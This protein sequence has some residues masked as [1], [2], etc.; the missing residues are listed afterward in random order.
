[1]ESKAVRTAS[2]SQEDEFP[3][4]CGLARLNSETTDRNAYRQVLRHDLTEHPWADE[5]LDP[6]LQRSHLCSRAPCYLC[7]L[8]VYPESSWLNFPRMF[9]W[10]TMFLGVCVRMVALLSPLEVNFLTLQ[11]LQS[12]GAAMWPGDSQGQLFSVPFQRALNPNRVPCLRTVAILVSSMG[13]DTQDTHNAH[14]IM[15]TEPFKCFF[16]QITQY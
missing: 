15:R 1:M 8:K 11:E 9:G 16:L 14:W 6:R 7:H 3:L 5:T 4:L 2:L 13:P 10:V 12:S